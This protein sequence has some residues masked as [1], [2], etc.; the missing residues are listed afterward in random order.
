MF[1]GCSKIQPLPFVLSFI[2]IKIISRYAQIRSK[3]SPRWPK[4]PNNCQHGVNMGP[5]WGPREAPRSVQGIQKSGPKGSEARIAN[6]SQHGPQID[7]K[8]APNWTHFRD[9]LGSSW[10]QFGVMMGSSWDHFGV[11]LA[12]SWDHVVVMMGSS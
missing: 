10:D 7:F 8:W 1:E 4:T 12:S 11:I 9:M 5:T 2:L 6:K 3:N